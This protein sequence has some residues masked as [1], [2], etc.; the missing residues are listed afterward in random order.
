MERVDDSVTVVHIALHAFGLA[1]FAEFVASYRRHVAGMPHRLVVA[2]KGFPCLDASAGHRAMISGLAAECVNVP[3]GGFDLGTYFETASRFDATTYC[4]LNSRS[5]LL[6]DGWLAALHDAVHERDVGAAGATGS[7]E[8]LYTD[9]MNVNQRETQARGMRGAFRRS[10][11]N[12]LRHRLAYPPFPNPHLRT[13]AFAIRAEV[14]RRVHRWPFETRRDTA[15]FENGRKSLTRQLAAHGLQV[16]VVGHDRKA[17]AP[18]EWSDSHTFW[19]GE[20]ENLLVAD[21]QTARYAAGDAE[22]R[23]FLRACAWGSGDTTRT[24]STSSLRDSRTA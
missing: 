3:D 17:Y 20:Q 2:L 24:A 8:S 18:S 5:V 13:N 19:R 22:T 11:I 4:F 15:Q 6:A 23:A 1:P 16:R 14:L 9:F 21:N 10:F 12:V 7:L